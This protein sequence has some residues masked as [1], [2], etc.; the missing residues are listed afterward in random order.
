[1]YEPAIVTATEFERLRNSH[2]GNPRFRVS[3]IRS[4]GSVDWADTEP[5]AQY[6]SMLSLRT[7][8]QYRITT[9]KWGRIA[10][11]EET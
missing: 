8:V 5:D 4:D 11:M 7:D 2:S 10:S 6:A 3:F 1:M 9:N